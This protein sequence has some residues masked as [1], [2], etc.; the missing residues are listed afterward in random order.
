MNGLHANA[1]GDVWR[2][3]LDLERSAGASRKYARQGI[4]DAGLLAIAHCKH[5]SD[6][7][8]HSLEQKPKSRNP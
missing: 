6:E 7:I 2:R 1:T 3:R 5:S 4:E 8:I